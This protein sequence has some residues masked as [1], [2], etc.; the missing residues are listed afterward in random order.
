MRRSLSTISSISTP[1]FFAAAFRRL[2]GNGFLLPGRPSSPCRACRSSAP[3]RPWLAPCAAARRL[4]S[5]GARRS[6]G[7][8]SCPLRR[9]G[10][11]LELLKVVLGGLVGG[12]LGGLVVKLVTSEVTSFRC[13]VVRKWCNKGGEMVEGCGRDIVTT[14]WVSLGY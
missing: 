1:R 11:H 10:T 7:R 13:W 9:C 6:G 14:L 5:A 3:P 12:L 4:R 2:G 8:S